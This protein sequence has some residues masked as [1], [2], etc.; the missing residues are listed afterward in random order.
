MSSSLDDGPVREGR[1]TRFNGREPTGSVCLQDVGCSQK[2]LEP[3]RAQ[4]RLVLSL[5]GLLIHVLIPVLPVLKQL[6]IG[7]R[8]S[9]AQSGKV[10]STVRLTSAGYPRK[11][12]PEDHIFI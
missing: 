11:P 8:T 9:P 4:N 10:L 1:A 6:I 3:F 12:D 5:P 2:A 7:L